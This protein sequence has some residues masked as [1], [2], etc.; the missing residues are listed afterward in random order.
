HENKIGTGHK[1]NI[2][3]TEKKKILI[4]GVE[5]LTKLLKNEQSEQTFDAVI[6]FSA[7][8]VDV[9]EDALKVLENRIKMYIYISTDSVYEVCKPTSSIDGLSNETDSIRPD[10]PVEYEKLRR[11]DS[12]GHKK[13]KIEEYLR[14]MQAKSSRKW[15]YVILRLPD[16]LGAR[17]S[18]DR[19]WFYQMWLQFFQIINKPIDLSSNIKTS[20]VYVK[21]VARYI[22]FILTKTFVDDDDKTLSSIN[23]DNQILNIAC[24]EI[25]Q[26]KQLLLMIVDELGK[27][28]DEILFNE[29]ENTEINFFPSVTR[30][31]IDTRKAVTK[32]NWN[33]TPIKETVREIVQFYNNAY[34]LFPNERYDIVRKIRKTILSNDELIYGKFLFELNRFSTKLANKRKHDQL[35]VIDHEHL[36]QQQNFKKTHPEL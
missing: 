4:F 27:Q 24:N 28:Q 5:Q 29:N 10:N 23:F 12:Y 30:G 35:F 6:D 14:R 7:Y 36:Q 13:L 34:S 17:D 31:P 1:T 9:V 15:S 3:M 8:D 26:L 2:Q 33:P 16:V 20:Y 19:W 11:R 25:L 22:G 32:F 18:T 21:D